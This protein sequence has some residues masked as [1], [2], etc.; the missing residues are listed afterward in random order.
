MLL[1]HVSAFYPFV[2]SLPDLAPTEPGGVGGSGFDKVIC[3]ALFLTP[4]SPGQSWV[5]VK[6]C[7]TVLGR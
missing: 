2:T 7:S 3:A 4:G 5:A 1:S 6:A